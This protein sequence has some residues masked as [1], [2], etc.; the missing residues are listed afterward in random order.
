MVKGG[1]VKGV[2]WLT[3]LGIFLAKLGFYFA[4]CPFIGWFGVLVVRVLMKNVSAFSAINSTV[5]SSPA[6][7]CSD[8]LY[9]K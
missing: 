6:P 2:R 5:H 9:F 8:I 3:S 4:N 1:R 7:F